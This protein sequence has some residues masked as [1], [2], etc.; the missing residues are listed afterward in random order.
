VTGNDLIGAVDQNCTDKPELRDAAGNLVNLSFRMG[1][2]IAL[3]GDEA[4]WRDHFKP[5]IRLVCCA[6]WRTIL[7]R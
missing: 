5:P 2:C 3:I 6:G 1:A 4:T 7:D